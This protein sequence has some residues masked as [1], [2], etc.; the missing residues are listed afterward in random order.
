[1]L[2][3]YF[4]WNR[5]TAVLVV[6][7]AGALWGCAASNLQQAGS[8]GGTDGGPDAGLCGNGQLDPGEECDD[9]NTTSGD[10]CSPGCQTEVCDG[11]SC[12]W[13]CCDV[14]GACADGTQD[15][16][17]GSDGVNCADCETGGLVC[18]DH[19]CEDLG[20]CT[21]GDTLGCGN[22]GTRTCTPTGA[23]G[24]CQDQGDCGV[25]EVEGTGL[26]GN[27]GELQRTCQ[28]DCTWSGLVCAGE[29]PCVPGEVEQGG[30]CGACSVD[31]RACQP[32]CTWGAWTCV[33]YQE[34]T[35]G[36]VDT[37]A[38]CGDCGTE[39]RVCQSDCTWGGFACAGEG[40]CGSGD[41]TTSGCGGCQMKHCTAQCTWGSCESPAEVCNGAD[42]DCDGQCD[43]GFQC[44]MNQTG[45]CT[46]SCGS[47]GNRTCSASCNWGN[48]QTPPETCNGVDDNC[49][50]VVDE[51]FRAEVLTAP[52]TGAN[53]LDDFNT[54][55]NGS[56]Q[57]WGLAC[58]YAIH[59]WCQAQDPGCLSS[60]Y[61]P[62]EITGN[63]STVN[64]VAGATVLTVSF[65]T[66]SGIHAG[67]TSSNPVSDSCYFAIHRHCRNQGYE[68]G[69][70][71]I[72]ATSSNLQA[73]CIDNA[74]VINTTYTTLVGHHPMCDGTTQSWGMDCNAAIKRYCTSQGHTGGYGPVSH[75]GN[76]CT[77]VCIDP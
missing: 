70:G 60:G 22:C 53:S 5:I 33:A 12:P 29:G 21:A 17:C 31:E 4:M 41:T 36:A 40:V 52:F 45:S 6:L 59:A 28:S 43:N 51:G 16:Q 54:T 2:T 75:M 46:T 62:V 39:E 66:L 35:P 42:D 44:C 69:F 47:A 19:L 9:G 48:C 25:G 67:C 13:G 49:D 50:T 32:D 55:C 18:Q 61:G 38:A 72:T 24:P 8:D 11:S 1:M 57:N 23:W 71:P 7:S 58:N 68:A 64:C 74:T 3:R 34:C 27:C 63:N 26:C 77:V 65:S 73:G 20:S 56:S 76:D 15:L 37:G 30:S 10:G 14:Y